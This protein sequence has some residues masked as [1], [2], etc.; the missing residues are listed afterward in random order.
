MNFCT[1]AL[2]RGWWILLL[3]FEKNI[4]ALQRIYL[5]NSYTNVR[6]KS[7][8]QSR[9]TSR[10]LEIKKILFRAIFDWFRKKITSVMFYPGDYV[11]VCF[12]FSSLLLSSDTVLCFCCCAFTTFNFWWMSV[13]EVVLLVTIV[14][15]GIYKSKRLLHSANSKLTWLWKYEGLIFDFWIVHALSKIWI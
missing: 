13:F 14:I 6:H 7:F 15:L 4:L 3:D 1:I 9:K 2:P 10:I 5:V 12:G 11:S 8:C